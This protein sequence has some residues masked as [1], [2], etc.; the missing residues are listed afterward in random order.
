MEKRMKKFLV[1]SIAFGI[2]FVVLG[3]NLSAQS[4]DDQNACEYARKES[5]IETWKFYLENF[6]NGECSDEAKAALEGANNAKDQIACNQ[7]KRLSTVEGW[8]KYLT[9]FTHGKCA[10]EAK[11]F[12]KKNGRQIFTITTNNGSIY[13]DI[14]TNLMWTGPSKMTW[15]SAVSYCNN[16][17]TGGYTDWSLPTI[18]QLR[19]L[20]INCPATQTNSSCAVTDECLSKENC[21]T[22]ICNGCS[23]TY[24]PN[25]YN[26]PPD[27]K[28][29]YEFNK[30]SDTGT[31]FSS[32]EYEGNGTDVWGVCFDRNVC[33]HYSAQITYYYKNSELYVYCVR[34]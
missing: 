31:F 21:H 19:T 3:L 2:L 16:L 28:R 7:A 13:T 33:A 4:S 1:I 9:D 30:L 8:S 25:S 5:N 17:K 10:F 12:L 24:N 18:S 34:K 22:S 6:P 26:N 32:S 23:N 27:R 20:I 14:S 15:Q 11:M 29:H